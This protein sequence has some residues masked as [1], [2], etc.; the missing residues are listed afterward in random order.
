M[1]EILVL[2]A[3]LSATSLINYLLK[4]AEQYDWFIVLADIDE[5]LAQKKV[6]AHPRAKAVAFDVSDLSKIDD[7]LED[8]SV[9]VSLLPA[10]FHDIIANLCLKK[11]IHMATASYVSP[12]I[13]AMEP[14]IKAK[15]LCFLNE[16]GVDPGIDHMSAMRV[17]DKIRE[18]GGDLLAFY[19]FTGGLIAP[20]SD[21]NPWH[22]KFT[23]NPRNV[24]VAGQGVS[25]F[26]RNGRYKFIPYHQL[27][28]RILERE[29]LDYGKFEVYPNRD[30]LKYRKIYSLDNIPTLFRGTMRRPGY[31]AAWNVFVQLGCT[32]DTYVIEESENMTYREFINTFLRY[33]PGKPVEEKLVEYLNLDPKGEIMQ[34]LEWLGIF[35]DRKIGLKSATPAQIMQKLLSEKWALQPDDKDMIVMQHEFEYELDDTLYQ[36][37]S[38]MVYIGNS[39]SETAMAITVG[40]PLA[41]AVKLLLTDQINET[42]VVVP[43]KPALYNPILDELE[44]YGIRFIENEMII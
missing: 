31:A 41:I 18:K 1:K 3:G 26:I 10:R 40:T 22:Y 6:N 33:D 23:W 19:S 44:D 36:I 38:S 4:Q 34:K 29:V 21:N 5:K 35:E 13:K 15:N 2:G 32:D 14:E 43:T 27:F 12:A 39:A 20:E 9:V 16:L 30:S 28:N 17:I 11:G 37:T 24:V 7:L 25:Q 8:K 42:G